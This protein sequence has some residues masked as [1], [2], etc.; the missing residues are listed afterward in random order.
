MG[1]REWV[2]AGCVWCVVDGCV[3]G[4]GGVGRGW[5]GEWVIVRVV[6]EVDEDVWV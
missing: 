5:L 6:Y 2:C 4:G 1:E 3:W